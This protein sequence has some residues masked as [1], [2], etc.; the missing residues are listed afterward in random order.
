MPPFPWPSAH[1]SAL[2]RPSQYSRLFEH[3]PQIPSS[4]IFHSL[5]ALCPRIESQDFEALL[6]WECVVALW[7]TWKEGLA[8]NLAYEFSDSSHL[9]TLRV[10]PGT[11]PHLASF[12]YQL[13]KL[14]GAD[15]DPGARACKARLSIIWPSPPRQRSTAAAVIMISY[16][17]GR[18]ASVVGGIRAVNG[19]SDAAQPPTARCVFPALRDA[20]REQTG[21][22]RAWEPLCV[23]RWARQAPAPILADSPDWQAHARKRHALCRGSRAAAASLRFD[24][25]YA[26]FIAPP[27]GE[28]VVPFSARAAASSPT[29]LVRAVPDRDRRWAT[30]CG[31][32]CQAC[33]A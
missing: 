16:H 4:W 14:P 13:R 29:P 27:L 10:T 21:P 6:V 31:A 5:C 28:R 26:G 24:L 18:S 25:C 12:S 9:G 7:P 30:M 33:A 20:T 11:Y 19:L 22:L 3:S 1:E 15:A 2:R 17:L 32:G 8:S 23:R